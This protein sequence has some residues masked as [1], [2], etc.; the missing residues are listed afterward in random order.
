MFA[1][2]TISDNLTCNGSA[3]DCSGFDQQVNDY[4]NQIDSGLKAF[5]FYPVLSLSL[6][7][8]F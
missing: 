3:S 5:P 1:S 8:R 4:L 7:S 6:G 2:P